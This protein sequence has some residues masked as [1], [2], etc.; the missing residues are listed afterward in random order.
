MAIWPSPGF[1]FWSVIIELVTRNPILGIPPL[2]DGLFAN[3]LI[4]DYLY[5]TFVF[6]E[7]TGKGKEQGKRKRERKKGREKGKGLVGLLLKGLARERGCPQRI[8]GSAVRRRTC[9]VN[10]K[11]LLQGRSLRKGKVVHSSAPEVGR[12][13][14]NHLYTDANQAF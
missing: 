5:Y 4:F 10:A 14:Q 11:A 6:W 2:E 8:T 7:G 13:L 12:L 9:W 1:V 3:L